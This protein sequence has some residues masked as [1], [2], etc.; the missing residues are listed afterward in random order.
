MSHEGNLKTIIFIISRGCN[1]G[2]RGLGGGG[3]E[4]H[5]L[6]LQSSWLAHHACIH[7][8]VVIN[9]CTCKRVLRQEKFGRCFSP[10]PYIRAGHAGHTHTHTLAKPVITQL[11][12]WRHGCWTGTLGGMVASQPLFLLHGDKKDDNR[13]QSCSSANGDHHSTSVRKWKTRLSA[14]TSCK[15]SLHETGS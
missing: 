13:M 8:P 7:A 1:C 3:T 15:L 6:F 11:H 14:K 2:N 4:M 10:A 12:F 9:I 5:K